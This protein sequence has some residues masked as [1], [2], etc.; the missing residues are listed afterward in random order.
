[1]VDYMQPNTLRRASGILDLHYNHDRRES[2]YGQNILSKLPQSILPSQ[3][4]NDSFSS[5]NTSP[6]RAK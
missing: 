4:R 5:T 3:L 2:S 6:K 1:M